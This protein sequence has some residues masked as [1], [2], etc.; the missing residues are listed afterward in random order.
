MN[1]GGSTLRS[2]QP[3]RPP[4]DVVRRELMSSDIPYMD[5][6][7]IAG[8]YAPPEVQRTAAMQKALALPEELINEVRSADRIVIGTP[9]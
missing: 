9:M 8:I 7:W 4:V 3:P 1:D 5:V 2:G 6:D